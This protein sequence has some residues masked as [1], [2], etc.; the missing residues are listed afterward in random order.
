[1]AMTI[2]LRQLRYFVAL[3]EELNFTRA[4]RKAHLAQQGLSSAIQRLEDIVGVRLVE[5]DSHRVALTAAGEAFLLEARRTLVQAQQTVEAAR[6]AA[7]GE[8]GQIRIGYVAP[9]SLDTLPKLVSDV[10][11][12]HQELTL[13]PREMWSS[14]ITDALLTGE[15]DVGF[16]RYPDPEGL[17]HEHI[18]DEP[19][20]IALPSGHRLATKNA[21]ALAD[22]A[23]EALLIRPASDGYNRT[24]I[25]ACRDAGFDPELLRT[26]VHGNPALG[27]VAEGRAFALVSRSLASV[28][29]DGI[30][31]VELTPPVPTVP[32]ELLWAP[33]PGPAVEL[34]V[35]V[36]RSVA[37]RENWLKRPRSQAA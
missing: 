9:V 36:V 6:R 12:R 33:D 3:A 7:R 17:H 29:T 27:P 15:L 19:L 23:T 21:V 28:Q 13:V 11:R 8:R 14:E 31:F 32:V 35:N 4:A 10:T 37:H 5:R 34:F 22:L 16:A 24:V 25:E 30:T 2:E 1:M 26:P 20:L 18:R